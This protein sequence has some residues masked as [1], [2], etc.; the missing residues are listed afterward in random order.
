MKTRVVCFAN[1]KGGSGKST[2]CSNVAFSLSEEGKRILLIDG[3]MQMNLSLSFFGEEEILRFSEGENNLFGVME[4]G[5]SLSESIV[6]TGLPGLSLVPGSFQL[7]EIEEVLFRK[8]SRRDLLWEA[9]QEIR[10][11]GKY[12]YI[13]I[14]APPTLGLWVRNLLTASD[15]VVIPVE[16]SPWG[17]FGVANMISYVQ[18]CA[19]DA[20]GLSIAGLVL[21]RVDVRKNYFKETRSLL[22]EMGEVRVFESMIRLDSAIE[23]AQD[24]SMPVGQYKHASRSAGEYR[25]LAKEIVR[26]VR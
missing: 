11:A 1:N 13:F 23:W 10:E 15:H 25:A 19:L 3:D 4:K 2:T 6:K 8:K 5:K 20:P 9:L 22:K 26:A 24:N 17:L 7:C 12:H 14:D 16:A 18:E 21:T